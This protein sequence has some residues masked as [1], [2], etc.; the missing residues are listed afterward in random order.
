MADDLDLSFFERLRFGLGKNTVRILMDLDGAVAPEGRL[1]EGSYKTF[2]GSGYANWRVRNEVL[3]WLDERR[4]DE[5]VELIWSSTWQGYANSILEESGID[6][7]EWI[8]FDETYQNPGDWYKRDGIR[9]FLED[10]PDPIVLVDDELPPAFLRLQ[11]PRIL[12]IKTDSL[13]GL[14][15]EDLKRIDSFI[16]DYRDRK[17]R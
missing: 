13:R 2:S 8:S 1:P 4:S 17:I 6:P 16:D 9:L 11:N 3:S 7:I 10:A 12:P 14:T 5:R 15:D